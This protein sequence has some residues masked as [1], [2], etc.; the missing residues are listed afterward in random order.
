MNG[1]LQGRGGR[2]VV[3]A[4][5]VS[6]AAGCGGG[7]GGGGGIAWTVLS[8]SPDVS[9]DLNGGDVVTVTG[10][11]FNAAGVIGA[12]FGASPGFNF[13]LVNNTTFRIT[14]PPAPGGSAGTVAIEVLSLNAGT[15]LV[16]GAYTYV[17]SQGPPQPTTI[18]PT[19]YTP[20][21]AE[22]FS[23][24]GSNLGPSSG[25]VTVTYG[26]VGAVQ[27]NVS[28]T[29]QFV[30]GN[31][32]I[33]GL[34]PAGAVTVTV[35]SGTQSGNVPTQVNYAWAAPTALALAGQS[36]GNLA[37]LGPAHA[38]LCVSGPQG[39]PF[40]WGDLNDEIVI[41]QGPPA[42]TQLTRLT[43]G[44]LSAAN[45]VP[46]VLDADTVA[47]YSIGL[48]GTAGDID[49]GVWVVTNAR[50]AT[51]AT[52][53]RT[54]PYLNSTP[55]AAI[56]STHIA[57]GRAG[58]DLTRGTA[59]DELWAM[60]VTTGF[61]VQ[62]GANVGRLDL[63]AGPTASISIP[64]SADGDTVF[65]MTMGGDGAPL[66]GDDTLVRGKVSQ[67]GSILTAGASWLAARPVALGATLA[68]GVGGPGKAPGTSNDDLVV[69][70]E[71]GG[72]LQVVRHALNTP[73]NAGA[74]AP[75]AH[76][77]SGLA[78]V[79][80]SG[81]NGV[82]GDADDALVV[83]TDVV[84]GTSVNAPLGGGT[85]V[86]S[87]LGS[88]DLVVFTAPGRALRI[89]GDASEQQ[90]FLS[91][92][93]WAQGFV[94]LTD[95]DRAFAIGA[96]PDSLPNSGDE[97]LLVRQ[98]RALGAVT[99]GVTLPLSPAA[100]APA[101]GTEPFVPVGAWGLLQ[102]PGSPNPVPTFGDANDVLVLARY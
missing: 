85:P 56:S 69:F 7:G 86:L 27:G 98:T 62:L 92:L 58:L 46:A 2:V 96:G 70:R 14:T 13:Q 50:S 74:L 71:T 10:T 81:P 43:V 60:D 76:L 17:G 64:F 24:Q 23:I 82:P 80:G 90:L 31:A 1:F 47:V 9:L 55:V 59:D 30:S 78:V 102:S 53:Y 21:G 15:K 95:D 22:S 49:D 51:P 39:G 26:A 83:F 11:N 87:R 8:V 73:L 38:V 84:G 3:A 61:M 88:G 40:L 101:R 37:R 72:I 45:S 94:P 65:V 25:I 79:A 99:D 77:G 5:F 33:T 34:P 12:T 93:P 16:F 19:S 35:T 67:P 57:F 4:L 6:L 42:T 54:I 89:A 63:T 91:S 18:N 52:T 41:V 29:S 68:A 44:H 100:S 32:P 75:L 28:V 97:V 36:P 48:N 20:T 66:T